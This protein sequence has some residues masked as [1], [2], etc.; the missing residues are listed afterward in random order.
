MFRKII[1]AKMDSIAFLKKASWTPAI[2]FK[3]LP[4][5]NY[6]VSDFKIVETKNYGSRLLVNLGDKQLFLPARFAKD[7][8][9][10]IVAD[11]N[12]TPKLMV[13]SG[14]DEARNNMVLLD[15]KNIESREL[16]ATNSTALDD[17]EAALLNYL[18]HHDL[19][20]KKE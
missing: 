17:D 2:G 5:G 19:I 16:A 18:E 12:K 4:I 7:I 20:A 15:F 1:N 11:L 6:I 10:E 14:R 3:D 13:Y 9:D 8:T